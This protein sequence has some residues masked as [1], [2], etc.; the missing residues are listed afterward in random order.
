MAED[1]QQRER[2]MLGDEALGRL[3]D[4]HVALFGVG[5]VGGYCAE[6]LIR[7]GV[8]TLTVVDN[9]DVDVTNINRQI[10]ALH[11][12]VGRPKTEVMAERLKDIS[13][14]AKII[15]KKLFFL[16]ETADEFDF[17]EYDYVVD[18]IDTVKAKLELIERCVSCGTPVISAMGAG[19]K[20]DPAMFQVS[21]ISKTE[22]DPLA[23]V[24]RR[25]LRAR[26]INHLKVV[27][28]KEKPL[29]TVIHG[30]EGQSARHA[31][32]SISFVPPAAGL[33][34]ASEVVRDLL[35]DQDPSGSGQ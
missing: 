12:T 3:R 10:I 31:P 13:P 4:S 15:E 35:T 25:E 7:A 18:A 28:S 24:M 30:E 26:G 11:S 23:K 27:Y 34:L 20:T 19:N 14:D 5:G 21:D 22:M 6:A 32:G 33:I 9:D 2:L 16:P 8:G 17:A 1:W 29:N